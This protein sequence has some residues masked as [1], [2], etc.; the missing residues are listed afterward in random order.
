M[1]QRLTSILILGNQMKND[2]LIRISNH[3]ESCWWKKCTN[4]NS[5]PLIVI[6]NVESLIDF[7][8]ASAADFLFLK[9]VVQILKAEI[10]YRVFIYNFSTYLALTFFLIAIFENIFYGNV[11]SK[12]NY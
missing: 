6:L 11:K 1:T 3:P 8:E 5:N 2:S 4:L 10:S 12:N 9:Q 7:P